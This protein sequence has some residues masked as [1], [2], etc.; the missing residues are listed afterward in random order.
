MSAIQATFVLLL[1]FQAKHFLADYPLQ[2]RFMLGKFH[3][4]WKFVLPLLAHVAVHAAGTFLIVC[5]FDPRRALAYALFD[6]VVH[7]VVDRVKASKR[8]LGRFKPLTAATAPTATPAQWR[9]NDFFWWSLGL[10]QML[11]HLTHY[12]IVYAIVARLP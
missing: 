12:A 5:W 4:G 9:S 11:H 1:A 6:A 2:R 3:D 8:Y 7:F 10:D